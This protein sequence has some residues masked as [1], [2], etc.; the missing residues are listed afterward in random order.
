MWLLKSCIQVYEKDDR[1]NFKLG[2]CTSVWLTCCFSHCQRDTEG[3]PP[4]LKAHPFVFVSKQALRNA[5]DTQEFL[6]VL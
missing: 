3:S 5:I 2:F 6:L 4:L 1:N